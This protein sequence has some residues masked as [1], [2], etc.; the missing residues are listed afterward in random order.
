MFPKSTQIGGKGTMRRKKKFTGRIFKQKETKE[1]REYRI[2]INRLNEIIENITDD[3]E[4]GK[5]KLYLDTEIE[6]IGL[7]IS[8]Y[9]LTK[10]TKKMDLEDLKDDCLSYVYSLLISDIDRPL[11]FNPDAFDKIKKTFEIEYLSLFIKFIYEIEAGIEKKI[12]LEDTKEDNYEM[13]DIHK[14]FDLLNI[15]KEEIPNKDIIEKAYKL[16]AIQCHPDKNINN[17]DFDAEEEF[18]KL[19]EAYNALLRRYTKK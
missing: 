17:K 11:K 4:Y 6:D 19:N 13:E 16:K 3:D 8:K 10:K 9:D 14:F 1:H 18:K 15:P 5:F 12:Y 2:K 7:S